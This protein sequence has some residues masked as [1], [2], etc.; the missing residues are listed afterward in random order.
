MNGSYFCIY[1][2]TKVL[3]GSVPS[4]KWAYL[5]IAKL[6][7]FNDTKRTGIASWSTVWDGGSKFQNM[8]TGYRAA[9]ESINA[10]KTN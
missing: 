2:R 3:K 4:L 7:G 5:S 9:K 10:E 8:L 6:G 1:I